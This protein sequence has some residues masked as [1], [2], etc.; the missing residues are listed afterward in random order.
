[1]AFLSIRL[2]SA[3]LCD[4]CGRAFLRRPDMLQHKKIHSR[5]EFKCAQCPFVANCKATLRIHRL[6]MHVNDKAKFKCHICDK[7]FKS[8]DI[9]RPHLSEFCS[10]QLCFTVDLVFY[11]TL[12]FYSEFLST[13]GHSRTDADRKFPCDRC[14]YKAYTNSILMNHIRTVHTT[15]SYPC[16]YCDRAYKHATDI[17]KHVRKHV[18][19]NKC[20][21]CPKEFILPRELGKHLKKFH[22]S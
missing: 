2:F 9:L 17:P 1:M 18:G 5:T 8:D 3:H 16:K 15:A 14:S 6:E 12:E 11:G 22:S 21:K 13:E 20:P 4:E 19:D 10:N 7:T